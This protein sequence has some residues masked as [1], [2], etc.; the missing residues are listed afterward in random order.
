MNAQGKVKMSA[1]L[2]PQLT[3]SL[4]MLVL[5]PVMMM[6]IYFTKWIQEPVQVSLCKKYDFQ[7]VVL[8]FQIV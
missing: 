8:S 7:V 3:V 1:Q 4:I 6:I 2:V 5:A